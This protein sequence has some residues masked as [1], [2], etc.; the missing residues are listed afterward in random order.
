LIARFGGCRV[1]PAAPFQGWWVHQDHTYEDWLILFTVE[2]DRTE[3]NLHW[4][5]T[6]K[7][8][9]LL[10]QFEQEEV[11]LAVTEVTWLEK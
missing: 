5:E 3:A 7:H 8:Q 6:Y 9:T 4:F 2:G 10:T 11:Y 1:Q